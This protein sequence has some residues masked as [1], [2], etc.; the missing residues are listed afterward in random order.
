MRDHLAN[1]PRPPVALVAREDNLVERE[2]GVVIKRNPYTDVRVA[3]RQRRENAVPLQRGA[4]RY[5]PPDEAYPGNGPNDAYYREW[6]E[7]AWVG[8]HPDPPAENR[9]LVEDR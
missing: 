5:D 3:D 4:P 8:H 7:S 6:M 2:D 9:Y 1:L